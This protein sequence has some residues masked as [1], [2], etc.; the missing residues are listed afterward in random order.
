MLLN[1]A[2][3][4]NLLLTHT[5]TLRKNLTSISQALAP[6]H[7]ISLSSQKIPGACPCCLICVAFSGDAFHPQKNSSP[8]YLQMHLIYDPHL[9][10]RRAYS[11]IVS[12]GMSQYFCCLEFD[13][14]RSV[15][16]NYAVSY[17]VFRL[18]GFGRLASSSHGGVAF[19]DLAVLSAWRRA[20][21]VSLRCSEAV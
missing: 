1:P 15:S 16:A 3:H 21:Q 18:P 5:H 10:W 12:F 4:V 11:H 20:R 13:G 6:V 7:S 19:R 2:L 8:L 9:N 14:P 17:R